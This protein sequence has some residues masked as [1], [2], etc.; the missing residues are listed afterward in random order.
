MNLGF[1]ASASLRFVVKV[2]EIGSSSCSGAASSPTAFFVPATNFE[3]S[4]DKVYRF[5]RW[6]LG[7]TR[8]PLG[9]LRGLLGLSQAR[10]L[11]ASFDAAL[12][13]LGMRAISLAR[14]ERSCGACACRPERRELTHALYL[15]A[16][17]RRL[18]RGVLGGVRVGRE[19][20]FG[21]ANNSSSGGRGH[22]CGAPRSRLVRTVM[23]RAVPVRRSGVRRLHGTERRLRG[24]EGHVDMRHDDAWPKALRG[25]AT[26]RQQACARRGAGAGRDGERR[27]F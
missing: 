27:R 9:L 13:Q 22:P 7:S 16:A 19:R 2:H 14:G 11:L 18:Q 4:S 6:T 1:C 24:L 10:K 26:C 17:D 25:R 3:Q 12:Q 21:A 15:R 20:V 5:L 23:V 8:L